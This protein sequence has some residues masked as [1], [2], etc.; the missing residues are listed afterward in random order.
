MEKKEE[1]K[2]K[3][4]KLGKTGLEVSR[5]CLGMMS[6]GSK[7]WRDWVLEEEEAM[8]FI[9]K[10]LDLGINFFDTANTY[11][12]GQSEIITGIGMKK[13]NVP[14]EQVVIA[15]KVFGLYRQGTESKP[16][17]KGLS[18]KHIM[19]AVDESLKRLDMDYIDLYQ[20]HRH[21]N[22]TP[23]QETMEA[24]HDLVRCGKVRYIGASSMYA[25]Q[26][27]KAQHEAEKRGMTQFVS[28]QNHYNL[29]Y[30]EEE[31]EMI[32]LCND[33]G[34]GIIPWS[35]LARGVLVGN[36]S[37]D[38]VLG[39]EFSKIGGDTT[40]S[41]SDKMTSNWYMDEAKKVP[42]KNNFDIV[43][44]VK[45]LAEKKGVS[46]A[47]IALAWLLNKPYVTAPIIGTTKMHHFNDA[48][49]AL[50]VVLSVEDMK[51]LEE[52]YQPH[53]VLGHT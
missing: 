4:V 43:D 29:I 44:R 36:Y 45:E 9:Q 20:I 49:A 12:L 10:A 27:S 1:T 35:P 42:V 16:N 33:Q 46:S 53:P 19:Q 24:L 21:D 31:R 25:W 13:F 32:P 17:M 2:M 28:M 39:A 30:R 11:S 50:D 18:R 23:I 26:L 5:I 8:P 14:R 22:S 3:Y 15:T 34:I 41:K 51:F 7:T 38:A 47:T 6:Y 37:R 40:R 52:L 48:M